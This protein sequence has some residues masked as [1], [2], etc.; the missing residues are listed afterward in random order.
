MRILHTADLHFQNNAAVLDDIVK[1]AGFLLQKA[2]ETSPDMIVIAGDTFHEGVQLGS[3]ASLAA[4]EFV[5]RAAMVAPVL[6]VRGT[7]THDTEGAI[8]ALGKIKATYEIYVTDRPGQVM[9][10]SKGFWPYQYARSH[11]DVPGEGV[12]R[13]LISCFPSLTKAHV[14]AHLSGTVEDATR[15]IQAL[16]RDML[17]G[18]GVLNGQAREA[19]I[20]TILVGHGTVLGSEL[21]AGQ[22]MLG[23]DLEVSIDD[24]RLAHCD[25]YCLGH[26]HKPQNWGTVYYSG[27][28]TRMNFG[29]VEP[30]GFYVH[31]GEQHTFYETPARTMKTKRPEGLPGIEVVEDVQAGEIVRVVYS[32]AEQDIGKVDEQAI[33]AAARA[34]GA[35]DVRIEKNIIPTVRVRAEGISRCHDLT[36]KLMRWAETTGQTVNGS[37]TGKLTKLQEN[38]D[39]DYIVN[40]LYG[41]ESKQ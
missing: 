24:L 13:C 36:E 3:P 12:E 14:L 7:T 41:K 1:C 21:S 15:D 33:I 34:K 17:Q 38:T 40:E 9:L 31:D 35:A 30:K 10:T 27:S 20:T 6:I 32:V 29:E 25:L 23:R 16:I 8:D 5:Q 4:I 19:G 37:V 11:Y 26:I 22:T 28:I 39:P 18:W 2:Q